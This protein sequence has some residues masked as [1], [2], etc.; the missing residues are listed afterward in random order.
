MKNKKIV[1]PLGWYQNKKRKGSGLSFGKTGIYN[2]VNW[3]IHLGEDII[4]QPGTPVRSIASG[5]VVYAGFHPGSKEK[6]NWGHIMIIKHQQLSVGKIIYSLYGHLGNLEKRTKQKVRTGQRIG[7]IGSA[8][9][10]SNGW[11]PAHLHFSIY[12]GPWRGVV[13]PGY[14]K[15]EQGRTKLSYWRNPSEFING[16]LK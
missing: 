2:G 14:Y 12:T 16:L 8:Y 9:T 3:G 6:G 5:T 13:L 10:R 4:C 15:K 1:Y 7:R 11:W